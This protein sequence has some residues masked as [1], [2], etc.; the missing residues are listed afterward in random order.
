MLQYLVVEVLDRSVRLS[1]GHCNTLQCVTVWYSALQCDAMP[2]R[3]GVGSEYLT[4]PWALQHISVCVAWCCSVL[5]GFTA[6]C[7]ASQ[8]VA[9]CCSVLQCIAV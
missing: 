6:W 8:C 4:Q 5:P 2:G 1:Y 3:W 9:V 7:N